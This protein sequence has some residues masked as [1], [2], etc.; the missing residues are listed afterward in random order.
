MMLEDILGKLLL[1]T[2]PLI[3]IKRFQIY[4]SAFLFFLLNF[5]LLPFTE[6]QFLNQE[7]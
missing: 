2:T 5:S 1:S 4:S 6:N 3:A 7:K